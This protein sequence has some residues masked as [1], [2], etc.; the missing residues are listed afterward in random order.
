MEEQLSDMRSADPPPAQVNMDQDWIQAVVDSGRYD[1]TVPRRLEWIAVILFI[2]NLFMMIYLYSLFYRDEAWG[3][4]TIAVSIA[5]AVVLLLSLILS[6]FGKTVLSKYALAVGIFGLLIS[7]ISFGAKLM[8]QI[9]E[10]GDN[11]YY[12]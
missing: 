1:E 8:Q 9:S 4:F 7:V 2:V 6:I 12:T 10:W 3:L 5:T 11:W